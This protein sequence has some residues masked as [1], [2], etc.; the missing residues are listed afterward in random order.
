MTECY[1]VKQ[2]LSDFHLYLKQGS[3]THLA[4]KEIDI[5]L[6]FYKNSKSFN[7]M[8]NV[9]RFFRDTPMPI[10]NH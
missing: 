1:N 6:S 10:E 3:I 4:P 5:R 2:D 8:I 9:N 7:T